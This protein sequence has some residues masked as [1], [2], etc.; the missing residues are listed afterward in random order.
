MKRLNVLTLI[1][2]LTVGIALAGFIATRPIPD[3]GQGA[4]PATTMTIPF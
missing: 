3:G 1:L 2:S 4:R